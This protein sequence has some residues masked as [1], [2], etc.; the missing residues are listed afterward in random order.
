VPVSTSPVLQRL[1]APVQRW[2]SETFAGPT[3]VQSAAWPRILDGESVLL[4]AP[5][6]SGKTLA[7]F[8]GALDRL[9]FEPEPANEGRL[10]VVYVSPLRALAVDVEK[11]LERPI[12]GIAAAAERLGLPCRIPGLSLRSGDTAARDRAR[13]SRSASDVLITT[14]ESLY[15]LLT[16]NAARHFASTRTV[17]LD[18]VH[19]LIGNKRGA[20]LFLSLER[21]E[22]L[23]MRAEPLQRIGLSA[24]QR[25]LE[26]A[27]RWLGGMDSATDAPRSVAIVDSG[28]RPNVTLSVEAPEQGWVAV[29]PRLV[30]LIRE[31]RSTLIFVNNRRLAER[32]AADVNAAAGETLALA[33]H[34]SVAQERRRAI[35]DR[36]K[37]GELRALVATSSLE[38]GIDMGAVDL[39]I[40]IEPPPSV[41]SGL[42][43]VGRAGH[44]VG[45]RSKG[46]IFSKSRADLLATAAAVGRIRAAEVEAT[47]PVHNPLDVLAQQIVAVVSSAPVQADEL[48]CLV[49]RAAPF[50]ELGRAAFDDV[51]DLLSGRYPSDEFAALPPRITWDRVSGQLRPREGA[52]RI[53]IANA[54]TIPDRGLFGVFLAAAGERGTRVGEL[55]E[56]MVFESR[57]GDVFLLGASSWRI[58]EITHDR[59]LVSPAPG[60]PGKMPFWRGDRAGRAFELG[61]AMGRLGRELAECAEARALERLTREYG[62]DER[63]AKALRSYLEAQ[64]R[65]TGELPSDRAIVVERFVDDLGEHRVCVLSPFGAR[66]H[67][68]WALAAIARYR[69]VTG[70]E[71]EAIWSD[72]GI[73]FRVP[74]ADTA[75]AAEHFLPRAA[76]IEALLLEELGQSSLFAA[77][78][79]ENAGR[80]L[81]LPRRQPGRR[82]PLWA[83]RKRAA[84]LLRVAAR[85]PSFPM[86]I[87]TYRECLRD[88]FDLPALTSLLSG[89]EAASIA[90]VAVDSQRPSPFASSLLFAREESFIYD[91]DLP[92]A[93]RRARSLSL[94]HA[95]L[96]ELI[97]EDETGKLF[98]AD[99]VAAIDR[100]RR[101]LER[102]PLAHADALHDLLIA[103]GDHSEAEIRAR[104]G[105]DADVDGWLAGLTRAGRIFEFRVAGARRYAAAEDAFRLH[106]GAGIALP[107]GL[108]PA[109]LTPV[110]APLGDLVS[111]YARTHGPFLPEALAARW[112]LELDRVQAELELLKARGR[113]IELTLEGR[114]HL[115]D[116]DAFRSLKR[117]AL[118]R[119]R[120]AV[121][122]VEPEAYARFLVSW[123]GVDRPLAGPEGLY[124]VA[125]ALRGA[126]LPASVLES[127]VLAVRLRRVQPGALDE[128][129]ASGEFVWRGL[130]PLGKS[131]GRI[132]LFRRGDYAL[133]APPSVPAEGALEARI[134]GYLRAHGASFFHDMNRELGA[135]PGHVLAAL[136]ALVWAGEVSNDTLAPLR[137]LGVRPRSERPG[138]A[139]ARRRPALPGS[140][141]RW[142]LLPELSVTGVQDASAREAERR[143]AAAELVLDRYGVVT[144]E[145][146]SAGDP[147]ASFGD[148]Y[149]V[150]KA[151]EESG[152]VRRGYF[153]K[154]LTAA[155]F[156]RP[157]AEERLRDLPRGDR[158]E[159]VVLSAVD[160]A[161]PYGAALGWPEGPGSPA[162]AAGASVILRAGRLIGF[163][164]R[165]ERSL[166]TFG[167]G[168]EDRSALAHALGGL[169]DSGRRRALWIQQIDG[170]DAGSSPLAEHLVAH[171]FSP[172][173][174]GYLRRSALRH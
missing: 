27:A 101:G 90:V 2:F 136:W 135:F 5:T 50:S 140:E 157:G 11:N 121:E 64:R 160:P 104:A 17:I 55:D 174:R 118:D 3:P 138:R 89:I 54:G 161:S 34:G 71:I 128:L 24:T 149:P 39:V 8:L 97:G 51:L 166:L 74:E 1:K 86:L 113:L 110:A 46:V 95:R 158:D 78:F 28:E 56:E 66:L 165:T 14:P 77:R 116:V 163:L 152:R 6:G 60:Q 148:L 38:L 92:L 47:R 143:L 98:D 7:A 76:E 48:F 69:R 147:L 61:Q 36:L 151:M 99:L 20:H 82:S 75:P 68:P 150:L 19:S 114:R 120:R 73:V 85:Y 31:H 72:D 168:R 146:L 162:R 37:R 154:G 91:G 139:V 155:Q 133:L 45:E 87:E 83:I 103:F 129:L 30:E 49:R 13:F 144:R 62:F 70:V 23:R 26:E 52:K 10:S 170:A 169:V 127:D 117:R 32:L 130:E 12:A 167:D 93:E 81:L 53:A 33:H 105:R 137:S 15:L 4:T 124:D 43:R 88:V 145:T 40:Q 58:E 67:A 57:I 102:A 44:Q 171:G 94:D 153:V 122:P 80:A 172:S 156:A 29:H 109:L 59:V 22:A 131:D 18:E 111:R 9:M 65:A 141:G 123:Q 112:A 84:D 173:S 79:R 63:A 41:A 16:S 25:P 108:P 42:Q 142:W 106:A 164:A 96:R 119:L 100:E 35:E 159:A 132:A 125:L 115:C 21:I 126:A 134:R 107:Q